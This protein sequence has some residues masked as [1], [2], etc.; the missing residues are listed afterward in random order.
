MVAMSE[1][2][3]TAGRPSGGP[4]SH[5]AV[6]VH[7]QG[8]LGNQLF[9]VA[10]ART[11]ARGRP[12]WLDLRYFR[13]AGS[14][15]YVLPRLDLDQQHLPRRLEPMLPRI[16]VGGWRRIW[17]TPFHQVREGSADIADVPGRAWLFGYWHD[18]ALV[19]GSLAEIRAGVA[20]SLG[21]LSPR[22][23]DVLE[24]LRQPGT[25]ALHVR[26]GDYLSN[27]AATEVFVVQDMT[28]YETAKKRLQDNGFSNFCVFSD[29]P[30]WAR[31]AMTADDTWVVPEPAAGD[32]GLEDFVLMSNAKGFVMA[33]SSY[34]WWA[35][36]LSPARPTD[37]VMPARWFRDPASY[38][39]ALVRPGWSVV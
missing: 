27:P 11:I 14:R 34:S 20:S 31:S 38:P 7:V 4:L 32:N 22:G 26:R 39:R 17:P 21:Q 18:A 15:P 29:D 28:Y 24:R 6:V 19:D 10:A 37:V 2:A 12:M 5:D 3:T 9:Q 35:A 33:N 16:G 23:T 36:S 1:V 30:G 25:A 13:R 8:G